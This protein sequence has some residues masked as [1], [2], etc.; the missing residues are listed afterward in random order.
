MSVK[1]E[2]TFR[3]HIPYHLTFF[4]DPP[5]LWTEETVIN[6]IIEILFNEVVPKKK[7]NV[8]I[9][10]PK[11]WKFS[12]TTRKNFRFHLDKTNFNL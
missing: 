12:E 7:I 4:H 5:S 11:V 3:Y 8:N 10:F 6:R 2:V 1:K 9:L